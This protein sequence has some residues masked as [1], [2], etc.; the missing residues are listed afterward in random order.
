MSTCKLHL[1]NKAIK[2]QKPSPLCTARTCKIPKV[3]FE[4]HAFCVDERRNSGVV[5]VPQ[6][7]GNHAWG[8]LLRKALCEKVD[9]YFR[10]PKRIASI[11]DEVHKVDRCEHAI[12]N[13]TTPKFI[14]VR[15]PYVRVLSAYLDKVKMD[16]FPRGR[17]V[18]MLRELL[19]KRK[20]PKRVP[21][22]KSFLKTLNISSEG[23][24]ANVDKHF[25]PQV[26][27]CG[28]L[29]CESASF[30]RLEEQKEW[31]PCLSRELNLSAAAE[32]GWDYYTGNPQFLV[33]LG[34]SK[35]MKFG[36]HTYRRV[37]EFYDREAAEIVTN[38]YWDDIT[39]FK[40]PVFDGVH[41][42]P[43]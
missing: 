41:F 16:H 27:H 33:N 4:S 14:L 26:F 42:V 39:L 8:L 6:K 20:R 17:V 1:S 3:P 32:S 22:F 13:P 21:T 15:N 25:R 34:F 10:M 12:H 28:A 9:G 35:N 11:K 36:G 43:V 18:T 38:L 5:C 7:N 24:L 31:F 30:L 29:C 40:Y 19:F 37:H 23:K 2:I